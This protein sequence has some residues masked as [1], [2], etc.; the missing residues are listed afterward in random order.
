M[1]RIR[2]AGLVVLASL[3]MGVGS[4]SARQIVTFGAFIP[5]V[6]GGHGWEALPTPSM[7]ALGVSQFEIS[8]SRGSTDCSGYLLTTLL[9]NGQPTDELSVRSG[10]ISEN[11]CVS[12]GPGPELSFQTLPWRL[13]VSAN[14]TATLQ[15]ATF[16]LAFAGG[17][18]CIYR[19]PSP[20]GVFEGPLG[21][22]S[23][24]ALLQLVPTREAHC[25]PWATMTVLVAFISADAPYA[26]ATIENAPPYVL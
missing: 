22:L 18:T 10:L 15:G 7:I 19:A 1:G 14:H 23:I 24:T 17:P 12:S 20:T 21:F 3:G 11:P 9:G 5:E 16:A 8:T 13:T 26:N 4:A 6:E 25:S 2:F